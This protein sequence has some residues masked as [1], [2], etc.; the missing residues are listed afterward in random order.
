MER[1]LISWLIF[2]STFV[3]S[4]PS[5]GQ[6]VSSNCASHYSSTAQWNVDPQ[7]SPAAEKSL[8]YLYMLQWLCDVSNG[9]NNSL[10]LS[11]PRQVK[12]PEVAF[13]NSHNPVLFIFVFFMRGGNTVAVMQKQCRWSEVG[14]IPQTTQHSSGICIFKPLWT[15]MQ[16]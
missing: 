3:C 7:S 14:G 6:H 4:L 5:T 11:V 8:H 10:C 16:K 13:R 15:I 2:N 12:A 1:A 9:E